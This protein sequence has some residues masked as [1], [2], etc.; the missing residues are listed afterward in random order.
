MTDGRK[1]FPAFVV[2]F[3]PATDPAAGRYEGR[4]E[5]VASGQVFRFDALEELLDFLKQVLLADQQ[6]DP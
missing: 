1:L 5:H 2:Q 6:A 3:Y 4:V